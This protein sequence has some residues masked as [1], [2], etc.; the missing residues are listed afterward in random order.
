MLKIKELIE[1]SNRRNP[2]RNRTRENNYYIKYTLT[3][4][5]IKDYFPDNIVKNFD[6]VEI[7]KATKGTA[8]SELIKR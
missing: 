3:N 5:V 7:T 6:Y 4:I 8:T 1:N 2:K